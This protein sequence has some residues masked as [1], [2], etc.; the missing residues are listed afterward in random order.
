MGI[1][2]R[3]IFVG[4]TFE[5]TKGRLQILKKTTE[6]NSTY[7]MDGSTGLHLDFK[8]PLAVFLPP[9]LIPSVLFT[10]EKTYR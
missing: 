7:T 9:G 3:V 2:K 4:K 10:N 8:K 6:I 1:W 5:I